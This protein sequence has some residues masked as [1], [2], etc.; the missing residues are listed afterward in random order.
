M[1]GVSVYKQRER[2]ERVQIVGILPSLPADRNGGF[3]SS[4]SSA[5]SHGV[6]PRALEG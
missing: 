1:D 4:S 6:A 5:A 2:A 3:L